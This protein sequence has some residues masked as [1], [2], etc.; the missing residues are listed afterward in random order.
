MEQA[1]LSAWFRCWAN[2]ACRY[3]RWI[4]ALASCC[5]EPDG[6]VRP[7]A[8]RRLDKLVFLGHNDA[9]GISIMYRLLLQSTAVSQAMGR[10][11]NFVGEFDE[12]FGYG[13][14]GDVFLRNAASGQCAVLFTVNPEIVALGMNSITAFID[15]FLA[16]PETRRL[17]LKEEK[18]AE[19]ESRLG[20]L[21]D[22][23]IFIPVP[24]P[25]M[26]GDSSVASYKKGNFFTYMELVGELQDIEPSRAVAT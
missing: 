23:E 2:A 5:A 13:Y 25:F 21:D 12:V 14:L 19:I 4:L 20:S 11:A 6:R 17:I 10:W 7:K 9:K 1:C 24:F 18:V 3:S 26:G 8:D 22:G 16:H 15:S